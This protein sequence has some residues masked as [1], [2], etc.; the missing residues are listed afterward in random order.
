MPDEATCESIKKHMLRR[1]GTKM[2]IIQ[3][4]NTKTWYLRGVLR[5]PGDAIRV[6]D[7]NKSNEA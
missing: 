3:D 5:Y 7:E 6:R 2:E 1:F 4:Y